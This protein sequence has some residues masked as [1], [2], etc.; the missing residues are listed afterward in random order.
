[1][2]ELG[3][4]VTSIPTI[5]PRQCK[6]LIG[7]DAS[8]FT[9]ELRPGWPLGAGGKGRGRFCWD[10]LGGGYG[11]NFKELV[12]PV[13]WGPGGNPWVTKIISIQCGIQ[14]PAVQDSEEEVVYL[15]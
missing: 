8:G 2:G 9:P 7:L 6:E 4:V 1:M 11:S 12:T 13:D 5:A 10:G 14:C 3:H 15:D